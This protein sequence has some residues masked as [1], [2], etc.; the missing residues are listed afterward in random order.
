MSSSSPPPNLKSQNSTIKTVLLLLP[1]LVISILLF[2][3]D[4]KVSSVSVFLLYLLSMIKTFFL[5]KSNKLYVYYL[6]L[7]QISLIL[8][9]ILFLMN[10][11]ID[12]FTVLFV[13]IYASVVTF[14]DQPFGWGGR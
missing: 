5:K 10:N 7:I 4:H 3:N 11:P 8:S 9:F 2:I 13:P 6:F 12:G 1:L 14:R